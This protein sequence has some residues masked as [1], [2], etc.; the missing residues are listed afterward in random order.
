MFQK[1]I[2][3]LFQCMLL[4]M[5]EEIT[6]RVQSWEFQPMMQEIM[7]FGKGIV[8][9]NLSNTLSHPSLT[10]LSLLLKMVL[11]WRQDS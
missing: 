7:R 2:S 8:P 10:G 9:T 4:R 3:N 1:K 6:K 5:L 11:T